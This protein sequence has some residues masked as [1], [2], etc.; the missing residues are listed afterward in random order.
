MGMMYQEG[1]SSHRA[2]M[3][4]IRCSNCSL[5]DNFISLSFLPWS[6][7]LVKLVKMVLAFKWRIEPRGIMKASL[8]RKR[9]FW[10]EHEWVARP[11]DSLLKIFLKYNYLILEDNIDIPSSYLRTAELNNPLSLIPCLYSRRKTSGNCSNELVTWKKCGRN[12]FA[13][14]GVGVGL[15]YVIFGRKEK[16]ILLSVVLEGKK[17]WFENPYYTP[18]CCVINPV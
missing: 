7:Y 14:M 12:W 13:R 8:N 15:S 5:F 18:T 3:Q 6:H 1:H 17:Y 2:A 10:Q 16:K 4:P 9:G 11:P